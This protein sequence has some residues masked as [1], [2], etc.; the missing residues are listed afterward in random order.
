MLR[1]FITITRSGGLTT[2]HLDSLTDYFQK[3][4]EKVVMNVE[5]HKSGD[6]HLHA[7][8]ESKV[9]SVCSVRK[10]VVRFLETLHI[11][12][13]PRTCV[14]KKADLGVVNYVIKE[15][16]DEKPVTLCQG[17]SI[18]SLLENRRLALKD[19]SSKK[20]RG[21]HRTISND[22]AVPLIIKFA[23][24]TNTTITDKESFKDVIKHMVREGW[25]IARLK[26]GVVYAEVMTVCGDDHALDDYLEMQMCGLR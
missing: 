12:I 11:D 24:D 13:G 18:E 22:D 1:Y 5:P 4:F 19:L 8:C 10:H 26:I 23:K 17:W 9:K 15:V 25:S 3:R 2:A 7:Y 16:S 6:L 14:V 20:I 21:T